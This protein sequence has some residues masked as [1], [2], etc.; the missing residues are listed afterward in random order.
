MATARPSALGRPFIRW[1]L[2]KLA[3]YLACDA[4]R[5]VI[6]GRERL[7]QILRANEVA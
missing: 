3:D 2:R 6:I 1:S 4:A 7:R 5:T